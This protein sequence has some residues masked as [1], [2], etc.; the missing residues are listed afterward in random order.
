MCPLAEFF[1]NPT[2][3]VT[4][5]HRQVLTVSDNEKAMFPLTAVNLHF[6]TLFHSQMRIHSGGKGKT[7]LRLFPCRLG[8]INL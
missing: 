8:K 4:F 6:S 3:Y 1:S 7:I 5:M 2:F